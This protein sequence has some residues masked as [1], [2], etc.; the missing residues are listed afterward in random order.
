MYILI[1]N[2]KHFTFQKLSEEIRTVIFTDNFQMRKYLEQIYWN[3]VEHKKRFVLF[4]KLSNKLWLIYLCGRIA[5]ESGSFAGVRDEI[6]M[7]AIFFNLILFQ[8]ITLKHKLF[9]WITFRNATQ[10][11]SKRSNRSHTKWLLWNQD[12]LR[13]RHKRSAHANMHALCSL[14][15]SLFDNKQN[16][17]THTKS[18]LRIPIYWLWVMISR[19]FWHFQQFFTVCGWCLDTLDISVIH[20]CV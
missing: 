5:N 17:H 12:K 4:C 3:S 2:N 11:H 7:L 1:N 15:Y 10:W 18:V 8:A 20:V 13:T 6:I 14:Q 19:V 16:A 9:I